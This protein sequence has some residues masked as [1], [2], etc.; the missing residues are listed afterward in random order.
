LVASPRSLFSRYRELV[1]ERRIVRLAIPFQGGEF[2]IDDL[3][4]VLSTETLKGGTP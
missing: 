2:E 1:V 3:D 4:S